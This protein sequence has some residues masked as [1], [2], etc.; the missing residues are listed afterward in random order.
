MQRTIIAFTLFA[1]A[2]LTL[3]ALPAARGD[4]PEPRSV[5]VTVYNG[6]LGLV[7][8]ERRIELEDGVFTLPFRDV[9]ALIDVGPR[10][11]AACNEARAERFEPARR[12][13]A[14]AAAG[15]A[16]P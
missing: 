5:A 15:Q 6:N 7:R 1:G 9:A 12:G 16:R 11:V 10:E 2:A 8:D 4:D 13:A 14:R 3:G